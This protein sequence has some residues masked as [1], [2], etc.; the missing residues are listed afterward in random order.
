MPYIT[1]DAR[2][3]ID[4]GGVPRTPGELNYA[5]TREVDRYIFTHGL[6]YAHIND[7]L[8][9]IEGAKL[10]AYRRLAAPYEDGKIATNGDVYRTQ[11]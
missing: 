1:Q 9:A 8:G 6:T 2:R 11:S 10:E 5:I 4:A 3:Y 7:A